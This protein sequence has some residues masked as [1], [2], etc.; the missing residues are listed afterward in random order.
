MYDLKA[1]YDEKGWIVLHVAIYG[2]K[3]V[4]TTSFRGLPVY[5]A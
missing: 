5:F 1:L 2:N 3:A 4:K